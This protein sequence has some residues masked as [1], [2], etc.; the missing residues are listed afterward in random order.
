MLRRALGRPDPAEL[1]PDPLKSWDVLHAIEGITSSVD[2]KDPVLDVGSFAS[3]ILPCLRLL[4]YRSLVGID[5][6]PRV[7]AMPY[8]GEIEYVV[9]DLTRTGW[10]DGSF[11]AITAISV[12]E[13]GVE[14]EALL[15]EVARLLRPGGLFLFSTDYW[16]QKIDTTG[17]ELFGLPWRI[18]S[19]EEMKAFLEQAET[20]GLS[21]LGGAGS[22]LLDAQERAIQFESRG[23]TFLFGALRRGAPA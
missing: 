19:R 9:G 23:Y 3:A 12:I 14:P 11:A 10:P 20:H 13:H 16:P 2:P 17:V 18:F 22:A 6:D 21:P 1:A 5:L 8:A 15:R 7:V 4:D